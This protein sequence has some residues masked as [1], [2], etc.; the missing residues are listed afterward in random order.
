MIPTILLI[1]IIT[2]L[3]LYAAPGDPVMALISPDA[4]EEAIQLMREKFGLDAP[5]Y[6]RYWNWLK[7]VTKGNF[8]YSYSTGRPVAEMILNRLP[9]TLELMGLSI[10]FSTILGIFLGLT[11]G[12]KPYS[13]LDRILTP[14]GIVGISIPQFFLGLTL[15]YLFSIKLGCL[16][17][18]GRTPIGSSGFLARASH[19]VLPVIVLTLTM[20]ADIMRYTRASVINESNKP[21]VKTAFSKGMLPGRVY[22]VHI[23]K[24]AAIPVMVVLILR[25]V[26]LVGGVVIVEN[27]FSWPGMGTLLVDSV[28][29]RDY[30]VVLGILLITGIVVLI[31]SILIDIVTAALNPKV[32]Y[33][34]EK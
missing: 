26:R 25:L 4:P 29:N 6:V 1:T 27:V 7:E 10:L 19:L 5:W 13:T 31:A 32:R 12:M 17:I 30:P 22:L 33:G 3:L 24:N 16:P 21:Y 18:G 2:F 8:G 28:Q 9:A 20:M 14:I 23:F 34:Y 15:I 11:S